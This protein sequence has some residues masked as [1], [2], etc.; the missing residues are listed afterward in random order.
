MSVSPLCYAL[1]MTNDTNT[2]DVSFSARVFINGAT[3]A[4]IIENFVLFAEK[5][6]LGDLEIIDIE[7][8]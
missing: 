5:V 3:E 8:F 1:P 7:P 6:G 2:W 4:E